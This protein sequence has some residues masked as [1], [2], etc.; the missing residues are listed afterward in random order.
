MPNAPAPA[1]DPGRR[2]EAYR[3]E[4]PMGVVVLVIIVFGVL[5]LQALF[6]R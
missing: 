4:V 3:R 1:D 6:G 2:R 5:I